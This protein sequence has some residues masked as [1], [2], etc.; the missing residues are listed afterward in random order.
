ML[1]K[2]KY[3]IIGAGIAGFKAAEAIRQYDDEG[4]LLLINGEDRKPYKRTRINKNIYRGFQADQF[5]LASADFY[6]NRQITLFQDVVLQINLDKKTLLTESKRKFDWQKLIIATGSQS[7]QPLLRGNGKRDVH[8]LRNAEEAEDLM[9][10]IHT[11]EK[12]VVGGGG[13]QGIEIVDQLLQAGKQ[14]TLVHN[15]TQ[16]M[17]RHLDRKLAGLLHQLMEEKG[18]TVICNES[19]QGISKISNEKQLVKIGE[20]I[21]VICDMVIFNVG[22]E[23]NISLAKAAGLATN[24]GILV[25]EFLQTSHPDVYAAGDVAEH[26]GGYVSGLWHAS[27]YQ[28]SIAGRN[29]A[30]VQTKFDHKSFRLKMEVFDHFF[31][32]MNIPDNPEESDNV[33]LEN[34]KK[35]YRFFFLNDQLNGMLMLNDKEN[36][37]LCEQAVRENW[38]KSIVLQR[39][40]I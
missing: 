12:V 4:S 10:D 7:R 18:V 33:I 6:E 17:N 27:E 40:R 3:I 2:F 38:E 37:K 23:P 26:P 39:F 19:V 36:A 32:S 28:G 35:Y 24:R 13:V 11:L 14:V 25:N 22:S 15:G 29:L 8:F 16:L 34:E 21:Q 9:R 1:K 31:F 5:A 20:I 30:G